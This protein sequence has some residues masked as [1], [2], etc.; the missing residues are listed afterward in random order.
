M[1]HDN[2]CVQCG[3]CVNTC[4]TKAQTLDRKH[5]IRRDLCT[6]CGRCVEA[7]YPG[8]LK[9]MG[10]QMTVG[11]VL[12]EVEKDE[13]FYERSGGG[14]TLSGGEPAGQPDFTLAFLKRCKGKAYHTALQTCGHTGW[15]TLERVLGFTDLVLYDVKLMDPRKHVEETGTSNELILDNLRRIDEFGVKTVVRF[16][17]VPGHN[18]ST[19]CVEALGDFLAS[20]RSIRDVELLPYHQ[21]GVSKYQ[22]LGRSYQLADVKPPSQEELMRLGETLRMRGLNVLFESMASSRSEQH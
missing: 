11:A 17:V 14:V 10:K 4:P 22:S 12:R 1:Y 8:A 19:G 13:R 2:L 3:E 20:L 21:F 7:C 6:R 15:P 5:K 16:P 9:L 18:D